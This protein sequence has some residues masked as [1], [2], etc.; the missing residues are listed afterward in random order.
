MVKIDGKLVPGDRIYEM[1]L[2][3][4]SNY[5]DLTEGYHC[6]WKGSG[7][8]L[9]SASP[10]EDGVSLEFT[11]DEDGNLTT[12]VGKEDG[13]ESLVTGE[14]KDGNLVTLK[15]TYKDYSYSIGS[16]TAT[17]NE[18]TDQISITYT[19]RLNPFTGVSI[20]VFLFEDV[21][22]L[23]PFLDDDILGIQTKNLPARLEM[24]SS[25]SSHGNIFLIANANNRSVISP[26]IPITRIPE[27]IPSVCKNRCARRMEYPSP[28]LD[29]T[30][31]A[32]VR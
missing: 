3:R 7:M 9:T 31:S 28:E 22:G 12:A 5:R 11:Y 4:V 26:N 14:W 19:D 27:N 30:N 29:A 23:G 18:E 17:V 24:T 10:D 20:N 21:F 13:D 1:D 6:K 25:Y 16:D 15:N 2:Y 8:V 32:T